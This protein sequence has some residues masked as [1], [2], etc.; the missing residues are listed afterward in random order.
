ME[1]RTKHPAEKKKQLCSVGSSMC[2]NTWIH[3]LF[4]HLWRALHGMTLLPF[5]F[6]PAV[7]V[8]LFHTSF[9]RFL[10]VVHWSPWRRC[11]F[12][13]ISPGA[14]YGQCKR[15]RVNAAA[16]GARSAGPKAGVPV[17]WLNCALK[18]SS[19]VLTRAWKVKPS[20]LLGKWRW[21]PL[22][23]RNKGI[24]NLSWTGEACYSNSSGL[25]TGWVTEIWLS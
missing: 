9:F 8:I 18:A 5:S 14:S 11:L 20:Y 12:W 16:Q 4:S 1:N 3:S 7:L 24:N 23:L 10:W 2:L 25:Q 21:F 19:I 13:A 17:R 15:K 6:M 22:G